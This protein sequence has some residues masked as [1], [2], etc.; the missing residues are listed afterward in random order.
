MSE[1][2]DP[3]SPHRVDETIEHYTPERPSELS[4]NEQRPDTQ[5]IQAMHRKYSRD[6]R[7]YQQAL[8]RVEKRLLEQYE[9]PSRLQHKRQNT[10]QGSIQAMNDKYSPTSRWMKLDQ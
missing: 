7:A 2:Y 3:L 8:Q 4:P 5:V 1:Q 9:H 6:H 10:Q